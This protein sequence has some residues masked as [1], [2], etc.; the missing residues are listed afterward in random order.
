MEGEQMRY[1]ELDPTAAASDGG[2]DLGR[3]Q[4]VPVE[5]AV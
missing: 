2:A 1:E 3:L 4:N 5:V